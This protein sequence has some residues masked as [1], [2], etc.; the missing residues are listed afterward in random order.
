MYLS[1]SV[2]HFSSS[3]EPEPSKTVE[4]IEVKTAPKTSYNLGDNFDPAGLVITATYDDET[5]SDISYSGNEDQFDFTPSL[6]T[7]L[8][9]DD[10]NVSISYGGKSCNL[11]ITVSSVVTSLS[12]QYSFTNVTQYST[13]TV[14]MDFDN[15]Y[16]YR[17]GAIGNK[18]YFTYSIEGST[19]VF[20]LQ[21]TRG[22]SSSCDYGMFTT[23]YRLFGNT[24]A[25]GA[26]KAGTFSN[27]FQSITVVI[28]NYSRTFTKI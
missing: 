12:G 14:I 17:D 10:N 20:T 5:T 21:A 6:S 4:S 24:N 19:I 26:T 9:T 28:N 15:D 7:V 16:Y 25:D 23:N 2:S 3:V 8:T 22:G 27:N 18:L 11:P 1:S 13:T